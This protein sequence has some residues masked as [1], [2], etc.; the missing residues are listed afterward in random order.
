MSEHLG[1]IALMM[2]MTHG[3]GAL[4]RKSNPRWAG[5]ALGLPCTT[6]VALVGGGWDRGVDYAVAMA[7]TSLVGLT[8]AVMLPVVYA[9]TL[10]Q[11]WRLHGAVL[12]A[13]ATYLAT[14]FL[15]G[16]LLPTDDGS[17]LGVAA[18]VVLAAIWMMGRIS[19]DGP[20]RRRILPSSSLSK[21]RIQA[22]RSI[23]PVCCL[24]GSLVLGD[25][26]GPEVAGLLSTFPGITMAVLLI[27]HL[28]SGPASA[29]RMARALPAGNLGMVA[30]LAAFRSGCPNLG[31]V[32][33][34]MAGYMAAVAMLAIVVKFD[35]LR[36]MASRWLRSTARPEMPEPWPKAGRRF[37]PLIERLAA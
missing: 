12:A 28:E 30:F 13:M 10:G 26:F 35:D 32:W 11:G 24:L 37:S 25:T 3:F 9:R 22:V 34:T 17:R 14:S 7:G 31:L 33:G 19:A 18:I 21:W 2:A 4:G 5:L 15:T 36:A 20:Q 8:G 27:T 1:K 29:I 16:R 23:V 6:A